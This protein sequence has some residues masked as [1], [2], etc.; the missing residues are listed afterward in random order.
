MRGHLIT[1]LTDFGLVDP[2]VGMMKGVILG[3]APSATIIDLT[4]EVMPQDILQGA[5]HLG[6]SWSS[7]PTGTIHIAVVDPGVGGERRAL[8]VQGP[9]NV[10]L[11]PDNGLLSFVLPE[12][13][14]KDMRE[15]AFKPY[16]SPVP[17]GFNA[18]ALTNSKYWRH[19]VSATFHGR[20]I[21][22][23]VAAH[24]SLGIQPE[25][26]GIPVTTLTRLALPS[27]K[28]QGDVLTGYV[29]HIDRFGN[30]A[31]NLSN[32]LIQQGGEVL[33]ID[34]GK[35]SI[36][37]VSLTYAMGKGLAAVIGSHGNLEVAV[38]N[39]SAAQL[40]GVKVGD[41]IKVMRG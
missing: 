9:D 32:A 33:S 11:A 3:I 15:V 31:T 18:H 41:E 6:A 27:A 36:P 4:H 14:K 40:L 39:G 12:E 10:F 37:G 35:R 26:L 5:F 28:W 25:E 1:L 29:L 13:S 21:F 17:P 23:P 2:Y 38:T 30:A 22:A 20:D 7:F 19:P 24:L 34:I 8:L 16:I